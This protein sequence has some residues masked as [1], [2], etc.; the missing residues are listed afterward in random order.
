MD[1]RDLPGVDDGLAVKSHR[2]DRLDILPEAFHVVQVRPHGVKTL[3]AR[4]PRRDDHVLARAHELHAR[5]GDDSL[6]VLR[7]VAARERDAEQAGRSLADLQGIQDALR[8]FQRRHD[9]DASRLPAEALLG[10]FDNCLYFFDVF[11]SLRLGNADGIAAAGHAAE[12]VLLPHVRI[13]AVD[14]DDALDAAVIDLLQGVVEGETRRVLLLHGYRVLEIQHDRVGTVYVRVLDQAGLLCVE[15][16]HA[17]AK[18][19]LVR[20][21]SRVH[22]TAPPHGML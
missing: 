3:H 12:D 21:F 4:C 7:V 8:G 11:R 13:K 17:P 18:S 15:E 19:F 2:L 6:Q 20:I 16:H 14:A 9:E 22:F 10:F 1:D 5:S